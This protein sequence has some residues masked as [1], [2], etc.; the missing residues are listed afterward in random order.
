[1]LAHIAVGPS[2]SSILTAN[3]TDER[4]I[5][6]TF[7][8]TPAAGRM[9]QS[10]AQSIAEGTATPLGNMTEDYVQGGVTFTTPSGVGTLTVPATGLYH[11]DAVTTFDTSAL[12]IFGHRFIGEVLRN[13]WMILAPEVPYVE[14]PSGSTTFMT[15]RP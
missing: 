13:W 12:S 7:Q 4:P 3:I 9:Y 14:P 5:A 8:V 10:S 1:M 11:V 6:S 15:P 2:V